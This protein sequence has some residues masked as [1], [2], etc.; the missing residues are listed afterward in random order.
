MDIYRYGQKKWV[1]QTSFRHESSVFLILK[2][3]PLRFKVSHY[4][5]VKFADSTDVQQ[6]VNSRFRFDMLDR[7]LYMVT[8]A[9]CESER[10]AR[11]KDLEDFL[12]IENKLD[13]D[14]R[15][16]RTKRTIYSPDIK[17]RENHFEAQDAAKKKAQSRDKQVVA[18]DAP[19]MSPDAPSQSQINGRFGGKISFKSWTR[20]LLITAASTSKIKTVQKEQQ[21][22]TLLQNM[23]EKYLNSDLSAEQITVR[24]TTTNEVWCVVRI[25][26]DEDEK[27]IFTISE[28]YDEEFNR[29]V[30]SFKTSN[31]TEE[32]T[33]TSTCTLIPNSA[34]IF[35]FDISF[36]FQN[37]SCLHDATVVDLHR[38]VVAE[39]R[40]MERTNARLK[41][42]FFKFFGN[43]ERGRKI[44]EKRDEHMDMLYKCYHELSQRMRQT[45]EDILLKF[46]EEFSAPPLQIVSS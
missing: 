40:N 6:M 44:E 43:R 10:L 26:H 19:K 46:L 3:L 28:G 42:N 30:Y 20:C 17:S 29:D 34:E 25:A 31:F 9:T 12:K 16:L 7:R 8:T 37:L 38:D 45:N 35:P 11:T 32:R 22:E 4:R 21:L 39:I 24:L 27:K 36:T 2:R 14:E 23:T 13:E 15:R 41:H 33:S 18:Q 1:G 5:I